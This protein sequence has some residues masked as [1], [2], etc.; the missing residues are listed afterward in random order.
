MMTKDKPTQIRA[1]EA[2]QRALLDALHAEKLKRLRNTGA[3][4]SSK[5][6]MAASA[7]FDLPASCDPVENIDPR[8]RL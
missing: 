8:A 2:K 7:D 5:S 1:M 6:S 3:S 4:H